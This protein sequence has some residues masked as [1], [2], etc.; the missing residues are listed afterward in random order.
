MARSAVRGQYRAEHPWF[1]YPPFVRRAQRGL[2]ELGYREKRLDTAA[3]ERF[4][5]EVVERMIDETGSFG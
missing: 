1:V 5:R 4:R 2:M 3:G